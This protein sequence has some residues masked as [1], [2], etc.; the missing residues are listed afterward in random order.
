MNHLALSGG[1]ERSM[2]AKT[3]RSGSR[4]SRYLATMVCSAAFLL[5]EGGALQAQTRPPLPHAVP[6]P[7]A[8]ATQ[9]NDPGPRWEQARSDLRHALATQ[10]LAA[11]R[12]AA[13]ALVSIQTERFGPTHWRTADARLDADRVD[14]IAKLDPDQRWRLERADEQERR[15]V[16]SERS[17]GGVAQRDLKAAKDVLEV[18]ERLLGVQHPDFARALNNLAYLHL[19]GGSLDEAGA[20]FRRAHSIIER[21]EKDHPVYALSLNNLALIAWAKGKPGDAQ[22]FLREA[23]EV[24]RRTVGENHLLYIMILHDEALL[25]WTGQEDSRAVAVEGQAAALWQRMLDEQEAA[26]KR[27]DYRWQSD[28]E[29]LFS[30]AGWLADLA[31]GRIG[32]TEQ[33]PR[34][35]LEAFR[36]AK[37]EGIGDHR[38]ILARLAEA[39]LKARDLVRA[40]LLY[41]HLVS[42]TR[43]SRGEGQPE[44]AQSLSDLAGVRLQAGDT[45]EAESLYR[46]AAEVWKKALGEGHPKYAEASFLV[47]SLYRWNAPEKAIPL[48]SSLLETRRRVRSKVEDV[49]R[50]I[51]DDLAALYAGK[52]EYVKAVA[53]YREQVEA[54]RPPDAEPKPAFENAQVRLGDALMGLARQQAD[55]GDVTSACKSRGRPLWSSTRRHLTK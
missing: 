4:L 12:T 5:A 49:D 46:Q 22:T 52:K 39:H 44:Y 32:S 25:L 8:S 11:A 31:S 34:R 51:L 28:S 50:K 2:E 38:A 53:L 9:E 40:G 54:A 47:A 6:Q 42:L 24:T 7:S 20:L 48:Y 10:D 3:M 17:F 45:A 37:A 29:D 33:I 13:R 27:K 18:R 43:Q 19:R 1:L 23:R 14:D 55:A 36:Q 35:T 16:S 26:L 41:R 21:R 15:L 30:D